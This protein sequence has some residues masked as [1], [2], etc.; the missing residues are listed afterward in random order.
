MQNVINGEP[1]GTASIHRPLP[2][3][4]S[5]KY[6]CQLELKGVW[7][8]LWWT[9]HPGLVLPYLDMVRRFHG[10]DPRFF[11]FNLIG[12]LF[13]TFTRSYWPLFSYTFNFLAWF[14]LFSWGF[15]AR[16]KC[17][18]ILFLGWRRGSQKVYGLYTHENVDIYGQ[19]LNRF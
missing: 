17:W 19:P 7:G 2:M 3:L 18:C 10:A 16:K 1:N 8:T 13:Y 6:K 15:L 11:I 5:W 9:N 12:S 4:R 14:L